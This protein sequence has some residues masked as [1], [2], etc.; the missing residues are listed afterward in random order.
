MVE[1]VTGVDGSRGPVLSSFSLLGTLARSASARS[2]SPRQVARTSGGGGGRQ[3]FCAFNQYRGVVSSF[4]LFVFFLVLESAKYQGSP[5]RPRLFFLAR[6]KRM[7]APG[8]S[9]AGR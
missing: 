4:F 2:A 9:S 7:K 5:R 8:D 6:A 1:I 3:G